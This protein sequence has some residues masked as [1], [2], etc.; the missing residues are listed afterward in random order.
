MTYEQIRADIDLL[1]K[2]HS[3]DAHRLKYYYPKLFKQVHK[4]YKI[5]LKVLSDQLRA[6]HKDKKANNR[7]T[8]YQ[9]E[10]QVWLDKYIPATIEEYHKK[11]KNEK[12]NIY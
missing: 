5:Q 6:F 2:A 12:S 7:L 1:K 4:E 11:W 10:L 3:V 8:K 9:Q